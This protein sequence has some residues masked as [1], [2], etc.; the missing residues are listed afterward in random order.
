MNEQPGWYFTAS[1]DPVP[2]RRG[3]ALGLL[4]GADYFGDLLAPG[5]SN[6]ASDA[7]WISLLSWCRKSSHVA[8]RNAGSGE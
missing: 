1:W 5:L 6:A 2:I 4:A 3:D 8:W 7:S